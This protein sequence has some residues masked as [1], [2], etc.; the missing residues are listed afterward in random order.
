MVRQALRQFASR[1]GTTLLSSVSLALALAAVLL[2]GVVA[3]DLVSQWRRGLGVDTPNRFL[4]N[5]QPEQVE[6]LRSELT[7]IGVPNPDFYPFAVGRLVAVNGEPATAERFPDP[8]AARFLDGNLNLSWSERLPQ[9]NQ[10]VAGQWW[11]EGDEVSIAESWAQ[12][13]G[14]TVGDRVTI[15]VGEREIE[16]RISSVRKVDWDSFRVNF[17]LL[18]KPQTVAGLESTWVTSVRADAAQGRQLGPMLRQYPNVTLIDVEA[19]LTRILGVVDAVVRSLATIFW[20]ALA[21]AA[22]VLLAALSVSAG[23]RRFE[24]AL[25]RSLGA[26]QQTLRRTLWLELGAV[27]AL[28]G[29]FGGLAALVTGWQLAERVFRIGYAAPWWLALGG[30]ALGALLSLLAGWIVLRGVNAVPPA[31]TLRAGS[32]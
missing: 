16:A 30:A 9:A 12:T 15:R 24:S 31:T 11:G 4:L 2:L 5:I 29:G 6:P 28:G 3:G 13:F 1:P 27:G 14:L 20:C 23:V 18:Y 21:A 8:R 22:C 17:F 19:L 25:W 26:S 32:G 7:R 10:I